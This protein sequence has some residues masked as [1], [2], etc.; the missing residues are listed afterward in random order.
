MTIDFGCEGCGKLDPLL[1]TADGRALCLRCIEAD[2][3][4]GIEPDA[5]EMLRTLTV[6]AANRE[7]DAN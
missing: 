5:I 6:L 1:E 2:P 4:H 7:P 3:N